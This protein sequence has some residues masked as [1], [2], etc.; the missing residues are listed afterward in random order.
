MNALRQTRLG[1]RLGWPGM[2]AAGLW[3]AAIALFFSTIQPAREHLDALRRSAET[4]QTR[5]QGASQALRDPAHTAGE[6]LAEFYRIFPGERDGADLIGRIAAIAER[7]GLS[8]EQGEYKTIPD[9]QGRLTR[10]QMILPL[11]GSYA[12]IRACLTDLVKDIPVVALEQVQFER[13]KV[14]DPLLDAKLR[15]VVFLG[16]VT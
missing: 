1:R 5:L 3:V 9:K 8:L 4:L 15:L 16:Q 7:H 11:K 12:Q 13:Q 10:M 14:G 2:L 6:Q